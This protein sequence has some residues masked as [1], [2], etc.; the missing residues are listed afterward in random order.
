[1]VI[2]RAGMGPS[3]WNYWSFNISHRHAIDFSFLYKY[4]NYRD[5]VDFIHCDICASW[6][7]KSYNPS[8]GIRFGIMNIM[9]F[10]IVIYHRRQ[11]KVIDEHEMMVSE[12]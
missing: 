6:F 12:P 4:V 2:G 5:G 11:L 7:K 8:F 10:T 9:L 1:M 3:K